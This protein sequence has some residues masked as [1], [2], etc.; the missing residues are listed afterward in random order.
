MVENASKLKALGNKLSN[1]NF[2]KWVAG[3]SPR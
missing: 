2:E 1:G 3:I